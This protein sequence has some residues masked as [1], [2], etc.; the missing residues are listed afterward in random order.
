MMMLVIIFIVGI[1][2]IMAQYFG[3]QKFGNNLVL[4]FFK[5]MAYALVAI[6]AFFLVLLNPGYFKDSEGYTLAVFL[7]IFFPKIVDFILGEN[8]GDYRYECYILKKALFQKENRAFF[9]YSRI[10]SNYIFTFF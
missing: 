2:L 6:S 7:S 10:L 8:L 1:L 3:V 5:A 9:V 4:S